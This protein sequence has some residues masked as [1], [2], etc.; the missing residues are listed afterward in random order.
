MGRVKNKTI[1]IVKEEEEDV[2]DHD[3]DDDAKRFKDI[4]KQMKEHI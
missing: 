1:E 3:H 4:M 2:D